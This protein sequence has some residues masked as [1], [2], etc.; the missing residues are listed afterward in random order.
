MGV[1]TRAL[2][3]SLL[4]V[5][6]LLWLQPVVAMPDDGHGVSAAEAA[7]SVPPG[8]WQGNWRVTR[9]DDRL[10]T[11]GAAELAQLFI[12][13]DAGSSTLEIQWLAGRAMCEDPLTEP[14]CEW[15]GQTGEQ[16]IEV[17]AQGGW[18]LPMPVSADSE[19]VFMLR[20]APVKNLGGD[21]LPAELWRPRAATHWRLWLEREE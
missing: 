11:R 15:L 19:D 21:A 1:S 6:G 4:L 18:Q 9:E 3:R 12:M 5:S 8:P 13:Q 17:N 2:L 14:P 16:V 20:M 7:R 10:T